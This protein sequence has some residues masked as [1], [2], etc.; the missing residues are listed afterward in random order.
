MAHERTTAQ[1]EGSKFSMKQF[2]Q[3]IR[4]AKPKYSLL[5]IG[6]LLLSISSAVQVYVP[7]LASSLVNNFSKGIDSSLLI[8]VVG[9]FV[10]SALISA[11]GGTVLGVFGENVIQNLRKNLWSKLT[12]LKVRYFDTVKAGETS[13]RLV[14]DTSQV[15]QLL[16]GTFP[17]TLSSMILVI[18]SVYMMIRMDWQMS[19][20]MLVTVPIVL[21][22]MMPVFT[23]GSKIGHMRQDALAKF[24]GIASETLSEIRLVKTS[25]A[26]RQA[27][28]QASKEINHLFKVG[29]KEAVFDAVMQPIM[30]MVMMSM[31]FGLLAY[32]M[33]RIA[34]GT[35]EI[36]T[37]MSF[38]M[39]L[40]NL[41]GAIP[42]IATLFTEMAKA[43]G[44]TKRVQELLNEESEDLFS[45]E[46]VDLTGK[47]LQVEAVNFSYEEDEP[48]LTEISFEAEPNQIIAFAGP[49]GGGKSTIFSLLERFYEPTGGTISF[50][51]LPVSAINL[52][53]YRSQIGYVSQDSAIMAGTI[54]ENL[55]YG[56]EQTYS[57]DELWQVLELAYARV[58]VEAMP[59]GLETEVGERGVKISGGQRQRIAIARA[60][61]RNPKILMLDEATA[62]LDSESEMMVQ[63]ALSNLMKGRTTLVIAH[64]LATIVD[65]DKIYFIEKGKVTGSGSHKQLVETHEKYANYVSEQFIQGEAV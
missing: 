3:L 51:G 50:D 12:T 23:F 49:S 20:I 39:Y 7:Q 17:Q 1:L 15:K 30:M 31:I 58:F 52:A 55:T 60:F 47:K 16:A 29:K 10:S 57:D 33:H 61:L 54:R 2:M 46:T 41:I 4:T 11:I 34:V 26:E 43:A 35:M 42:S 27:Q 25:N 38:L 56:L 45:G 63:K 36:G 48:I 9:L 28:E 37:L 62:S 53:D 8:K 22:L 44:S 6:I 64:R 24:N 40:F 59:E 13:S 14:N 21:L 18:G 19:V 65:S 5:I 32:G